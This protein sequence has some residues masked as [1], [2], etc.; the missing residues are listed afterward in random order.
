MAELVRA[1]R[2]RGDVDTRVR[3]FGM[4]RDEDGTYG[5]ADLPDLAD[6]NPALQTMGVD[7][8][9]A[10][11]CLGAD[12][13]HSHT[14][15]ANFAG[16]IG[17]PAR[18]HAARRDRPQ[19]RAD[20]PVEGRAARG[21]L[22]GVV[23][24]RAHGLRGRRRRHRGECRHARGRA[25]RLPLDRPR[26][27]PRRAQRHRLAA[28]AAR[29]R[30]GHRPPSRGRPGPP[31]GHLRRAHHP[32]EGPALPA[33][34]GRVAAAGGAGR[35]VRRRAGHP[36]DPGRGRGAHGH[37]ALAA[38]RGRVDPRDAAARRGR[39]PAELRHRLRVPLRLRAARHRQPRG[40]G[41]RA[42]GR[43]HRDR[44]H[45]RGGRRTARPAGWCRS[46]RCRTAPGSPSTQTGSSPTSP[47]PSP[48]R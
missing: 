13:V 12:L 18:R 9:M 44:R 39:G 20:A 28:V 43:G 3:C 27:G 24:R 4:P 46:S 17:I 41:L 34:R 35:A 11:D 32:P 29:P 37:A 47:R 31:V 8:R 45:P 38:R 10:G 36:G 22:P 40:D 1:L 7:L 33:A 26:A 21:R 23:V 16:H 25:A 48:R 2:D 15:Y 30:R 5:Y 6:A 19:P 42:A 14:W